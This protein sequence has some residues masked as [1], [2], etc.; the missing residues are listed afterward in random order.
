MNAWKQQQKHASAYSRVSKQNTGSINRTNN[1]QNG[2]HFCYPT[3]FLRNRNAKKNSQTKK[4]E[5]RIHKTFSWWFFKTH[6]YIYSWFLLFFFRHTSAKFDTFWEKFK[7]KINS[8]LL[9]EKRKAFNVQKRFLY[10]KVFVYLFRNYQCINPNDAIS[11]VLWNSI[12]ETET[13]AEEETK[14]IYAN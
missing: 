6:Q 11:Y 7:H 1:I 3:I 9:K 4:E 8:S 2:I 5:I 13:K 12:K 10:F 14:I